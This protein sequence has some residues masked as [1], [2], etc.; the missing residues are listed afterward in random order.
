MINYYLT[1]KNIDRLARMAKIR[2][3]SLMEHSYMVAVLFR[4][5][6]SKEDVPYDMCVFEHILHHDLLEAVSSD[7]PYDVKTLSQTTRK[8]WETIENEILKEH[9]LLRRYSDDNIKQTLSPRQ[10]ELFKACDMLDLWVFLKQE[11]SLGN[12]NKDCIEITQRC[13]DI[14]KGKFKHIDSFM[15]TFKA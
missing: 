13:V 11:Q 10:F 9:H 2:R 8:S 12:T 14:I 4:Y 5:F 7:L 15:E 1:L 3:Y 6:A